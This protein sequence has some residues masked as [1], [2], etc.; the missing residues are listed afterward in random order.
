MTNPSLPDDGIIAFTVNDR[1]VEIRAPEDSSLL[2]ALRHDLELKATRIGCGEGNCGAC[3]V[4]VDGLPVQS[5]T[6]PLWAAKN[7]RVQTGAMRLL[8]QRHH[9]DGGGHARARSPGGPQ[10]D[11]RRAR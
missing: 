4:L 8:H 11:H 7:H 2:T 6:T 3:T 5:C 1:D 9:H 10:S